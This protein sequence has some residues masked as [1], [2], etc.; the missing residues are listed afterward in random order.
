M[1]A[2]INQQLGA[3][4]TALRKSYEK[5]IL[6]KYEVSDVTLEEALHALRILARNASNGTVVPN[7]IVKSPELG[8]ATVSLNLTNVPLSEV[9]NYL[10][11]LSGARL[12]YEK[13][14]VI[15]S[16]PAS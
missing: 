3:D 10:S 15:L 13:S 2:Q 6:P 5:V 1:M 4:N 9:L 14:G 7:I 11:Q 16:H 8:K 12:T